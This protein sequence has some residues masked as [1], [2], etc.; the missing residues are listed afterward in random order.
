[1]KNANMRENIH[2]N[3]KD[4]HTL[5]SRL[6][7]NNENLMLKKVIQNSFSTFTKILRQLN[8]ECL[9]YYL[10]GGTGSLEEL[11]TMGLS[12]TILGGPYAV[13]PKCREVT[14]DHIMKIV[15]GERVTCDKCGGTL[16]LDGADTDSVYFW[17]PVNS[18][19]HFEV[20]VNAEGFKLAHDYIE[21][22]IQS[23]QLSS[24]ELVITESPTERVLVYRRV[25]VK[26]DGTVP[27]RHYRVPQF[28]VLH[29]EL[30]KF[31]EAD[32]RS[33]K[34]IL[35]PDY[36]GLIDLKRINELQIIAL[37]RGTFATG[38]DGVTPYEFFEHFPEMED[39]RML[40]LSPE[41]LPFSVTLNGVLDIAEGSDFY[42]WFM[43]KRH[44]RGIK[45][46]KNQFE[47]SGAR[48]ND[49]MV[50]WMSRIISMKSYYENTDFVAMHYLLSL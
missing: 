36:A 14:S 19:V 37:Q 21:S 33:G 11:Y 2:T 24:D 5:L 30:D 50:A 22:L 20:C 23:L 41:D 7:K 46:I 1:M 26:C 38:A 9:P 34:S 27:N 17:N 35:A 28:A 48:A 16:A 47:K 31:A 43:D 39:I 6:G 25:T 44:K 49:L 15:N 13:C 8:E 32:L 29:N 3:N 45:A 18:D 12:K 40:P 10:C 42:M 4:I